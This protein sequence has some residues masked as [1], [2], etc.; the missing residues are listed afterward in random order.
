MGVVIVVVV[1]FLF[2]GL[3]TCDTTVHIN[4][5]HVQE[6]CQQLVQ[7]CDPHIRIGP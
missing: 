6:I 4:D 1:L 5:P 2:L 7:H 3:G